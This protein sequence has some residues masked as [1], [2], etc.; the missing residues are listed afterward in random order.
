MCIDIPP[1]IY[2]R[3]PLEAAHDLVEAALNGGRSVTVRYIRRRNFAE[4]FVLVERLIL[5][6]EIRV[7]GLNH[8]NSEVI[9]DPGVFLPVWVILQLL[10]VFLSVAN[11][12]EFEHEHA[13]VEAAQEMV[14]I[15]EQS[16]LEL[17]DRA[18]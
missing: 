17:L 11:Q 1:F 8:A 15:D 4:Y 9:V 6:N 3:R 16:T 10:E 18:Q 7:R 2:R 12:T 14:R 5:R 13:V